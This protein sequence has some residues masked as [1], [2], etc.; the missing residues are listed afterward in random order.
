V[1]ASVFPPAWLQ[2]DASAPLL[3]PGFL[4]DSLQGCPA[5]LIVLYDPAV[6]AP[7]SEGDFLGIMSP[8]CVMQTLQPMLRLPLNRRVA[9]ACRLGYPRKPLVPEFVHRNSYGNP[10]HFA[11]PA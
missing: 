2:P 3:E 4:R 1:L 11:A 10:M 8:G 7:G 5:L 6:C 9:F